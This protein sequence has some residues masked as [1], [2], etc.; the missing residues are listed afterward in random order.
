MTWR[1]LTIGVVVGGTI[2]VG[3]S[4]VGGTVVVGASVGRVDVG[5][6]VVVGA[7]VGRVPMWAGPVVVGASVVGVVTGGRSSALRAG[8]R[9]TGERD[10]GFAGRRGRRPESSYSDGLSADLSIPNHHMH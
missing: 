4:V 5:G 2:V 9:R 7:S 1:F 10:R 3:A 8:C 6:T